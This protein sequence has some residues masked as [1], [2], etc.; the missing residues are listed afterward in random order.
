M[1]TARCRSATT[2]PFAA[3]HRGVHDGKLQPKPNNRVLEV[4]TGCGYQAAVLAELV[5]DVYTI[6]I[7]EPLAKMPKRHCNG[8]DTKTCM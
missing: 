7:I 2:K 6:E 3:L 4:G 5:A 8:L 1:K